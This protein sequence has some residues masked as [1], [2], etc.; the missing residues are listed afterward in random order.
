MPVLEGDRVVGVEADGCRVD[1]AMTVVAAGAQ[2]AVARLLGADRVARRTVRAGDPHLRRHPPPRRRPPRS[3][4]VAARRARHADPGIRLDVPGR[5]R[6]GEHR[7]RCALDDEGLQEAQPQ[8][9]VGGL[10][11]GRAGRLGSRARPRTTAGVAAADV[12]TAPARAGLG[13]HRRR[14]RADQPDERRG[15]R[16]RAGIGDARRRSLPRRSGIGPGAVR[17]AGRRA[18]RRLPPHGPP[19]LVPHRPPVDPAP[20]PAP[21]GRAPTPSP[22]SPWR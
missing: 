22:T 21:V 9:A 17:P 1:A 14:G 8:H 20:R 11:A 6:H 4:P 7:R 3:V 10:P 2:G 5:R 12:G 15:H 19:V 18:L 16:L 13:R